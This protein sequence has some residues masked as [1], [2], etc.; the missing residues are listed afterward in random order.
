MRLTYFQLI[1]KKLAQVKMNI[2]V[3]PLPRRWLYLRSI[4]P[5][6][7][8]NY[9]IAGTRRNFSNSIKSK[10]SNADSFQ[11]VLLTKSLTSNKVLS[12]NEYIKCTIFD[13]NGNI[14][15]HGK[16]IKRLVLMK[17]YQIVPRYFRKI[18]RYYHG[19]AYTSTNPRNPDIDIVPSFVVRG[20]SIILNMNY[21]RALIRSDAVVIFDSFR[22]NSGIRLNESHS[23]G[24]FLR[25]ME[26]RLKKNETDKL[27]YE[28]RALECI[29][30]HIILNL[31]TEMKVHKNVLENILKRLEHSIDRA[32]LRYLLIQSKKISLFHQKVQLLRDQ[33]DMI[34]EKDDL[35]NAMYLTEIK[36]GRPRTLTNHAEA[37]ILLESYY[38]TIDEIVQTVENLKSQIKT[39]EEIINI[40]LD[41]NRNELML[42]GLKVSTFILSLGVVLYIS[43]LY[44]MNLENYIEESD[45]G[46]EAVLVVSVISL[47]AILVFTTKQLKNLQKITMTGLDRE[48]RA[49]HYD[50]LK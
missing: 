31:K 37:E 47:I 38:K 3:C 39:S 50:G 36:E 34:L 48:K 7:L 29:L 16:D 13:E 19:V 32:K 49:R 1:L 44:G 30:I 22:H 45:G 33:L 28:F 4:S 17:Q 9:F 26:K 35:L 8:L 10:Q 14:T 6:P 41:S 43:A 24:I 25:D 42:L 15:A 23:H 5:R 20:N 40:M 11:D 46:F 18:K 2:G 12:E 21:I 27:P